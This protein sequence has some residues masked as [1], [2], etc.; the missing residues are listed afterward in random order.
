MK[1]SSD[2]DLDAAVK[3]ILALPK[4]ESWEDYVLRISH[5]IGE[6]FSRYSYNPKPAQTIAETW[7]YKAAERIAAMVAAERG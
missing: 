4:P 5:V 6:E 3:R 1:K 7:S 2:E